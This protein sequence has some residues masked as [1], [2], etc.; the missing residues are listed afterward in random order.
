MA[1]HVTSEDQL[2]LEK[3]WEWLQRVEQHYVPVLTDFLNP[4]QVTLVQNLARQTE[5]T[6]YNSADL[7]L[8]EQSRLL[9]APD[10]YQLESEDFEMVLLAIYFQTQFGKLTHPQVLGSLIH[11]TGLDRRVFGDILIGQDQVQ[12]FVQAPL[13]PLLIQEV[14][15]IGR[16]GVRLQ[17]V[18]K[19]DMLQVDEDMQIKTIF[20]DSLRLDRLIA[21]AFQLGRGKAAQ[22]VKANRVKV[23][24]QERTDVSWS[25]QAGDVVSVRGKGRFYIGDHTGLSKS[26]RIK[27]ELKI[28]ARK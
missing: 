27:V 16:M 17:A 23:N 3:A 12:V 6:I 7:W 8:T 26:G 20:V 14:K 22:L 4:H 21:S 24:Y 9:I 5:V 11:Q 25:L 1:Q 18:P 2:F 10:Y 19:E 15:K 13:A 28:L